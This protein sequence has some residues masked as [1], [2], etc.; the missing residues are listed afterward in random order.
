MII[1]AITFISAP[2]SLQVSPSRQRIDVGKSATISCDVIRG[3]PVRKVLWL[4]NGEKIH[5]ENL[6]TNFLQ[7]T[8]NAS[9]MTQGD[10][11]IRRLKHDLVT[12]SL[13]SLSTNLPPMSTSISNP[14]SNNGERNNII[15]DYKARDDKHFVENGKVRLII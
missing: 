7:V 14:S 3:F 10:K 6:E 1:N 15:L 12:S 13:S 5:V 2:L 4:Q 8:N 11:S 9:I